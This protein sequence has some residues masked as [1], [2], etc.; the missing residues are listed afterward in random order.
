[1]SSELHGRSVSNLIRKFK[2]IALSLLLLTGVIGAKGQYAKVVKNPTDGF[3][4]NV[5]DFVD[6][7]D[8]VNKLWDIIDNDKN[9]KFDNKEEYE[10]K[11]KS[12]I[13][14]L[15]QKSDELYKKLIQ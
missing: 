4:Q 2:E 8:N 10:Q 11:L 6:N 12:S 3:V 5:E 13:D 15:K 1:M 9:K 7:K 14:N